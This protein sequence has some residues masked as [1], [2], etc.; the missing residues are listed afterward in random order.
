ETGP[1]NPH[2]VR[3]IGAAYLAA[4]AALA[5][6]AARPQ[7]RAAA[8]IAALFLALHALIHLTDAV[9]GRETSAGL[10]RDFPGV[11]LPPIL[12]FWLVRR[13]QQA[14]EMS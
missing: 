5:W 4:G 8:L 14:G 11:F 13:P 6:C 10:L 2:F 1:L 3:D 12:A 9:F 7:A